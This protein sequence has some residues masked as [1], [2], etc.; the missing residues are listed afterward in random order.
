MTLYNTYLH[1]YHCSK[2]VIESPQQKVKPQNMISAQ[3]NVWT[4]R[5][6]KSMLTAKDINSIMII[7][8]CRQS[9]DVHEMIFTQSDKFEDESDSSHA[10]TCMVAES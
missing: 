6:K 4:A 7:H 5:K 9:A 3:K 1:L 2:S 8:L 10:G